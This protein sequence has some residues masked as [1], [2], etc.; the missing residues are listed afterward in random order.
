MSREYTTIIGSG[1]TPTLAHSAPYDLSEGTYPI[2]SQRVELK[3]Q[4][5]TGSV[6]L[7]PEDFSAKIGLRSQSITVTTSATPLPASPLEFRRALVVHNNSASTIYIGASDVTI[8]NGLPLLTSEK[9]S[10]D[11][12]GTPGVTIYAI[13][14]GSVNIRIL[15]LA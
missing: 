15:E 13:A 14:A 12:Q 8:S 5:G 3:T 11:I 2:P 6:V 7:N 9:M 1:Q 10:F 4:Y